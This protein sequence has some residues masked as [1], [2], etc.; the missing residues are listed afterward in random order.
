VTLDEEKHADQLLSQISQ[1]A[2]RVG[3]GCMK[4]AAKFRPAAPGSYVQ[5]LG[6]VETVR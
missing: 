5:G 1:R 4:P 6:A 2:N 3:F